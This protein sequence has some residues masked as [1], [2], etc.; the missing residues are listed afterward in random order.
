M[1][2]HLATT[3]VHVLLAS[4]SKNHWTS[5]CGF[6]PSVYMQVEIREFIR[7]MK[8]QRLGETAHYGATTTV[9]EP[10]PQLE[11]REEWIQAVIG[12][13]TEIAEQTF[14]E[15]RASSPTLRMMGVWSSRL[16]LAFRVHWLNERT[17][18]RQ[19]AIVAVN[20][21]IASRWQPCSTLGPTLHFI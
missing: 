2:C 12:V 16:L 11:E 18:R 4:F 9:G 17:C 6:E 3:G 20:G 14:K 1:S 10:L 15:L 5:V 7:P 13:N 21:P 19:K 8:I